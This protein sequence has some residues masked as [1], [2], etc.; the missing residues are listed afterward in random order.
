[1]AATGPSLR[2][3]TQKFFD[4]YGTHGPT[5]FQERVELSPEDQEVIE[6]LMQAVGRGQ[7]IKKMVAELGSVSDW[8]R[9]CWVLVTAMQ[10]G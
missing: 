7:T 9:S 5:L 6:G 8:V 4:T 1:M 10:K 2:S 3:A